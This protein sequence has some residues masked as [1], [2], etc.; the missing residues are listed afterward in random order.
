M[1]GSSSSSP[2]SSLLR[3][4]AV[5]GGGP[6]TGPF[7]CGTCGRTFSRNDSLAHHKTIHTGQTRCPVC[8]VLFTRK[9]TMKCHLFTAHGI[10]RNENNKRK[11]HPVYCD[12]CGKGFQIRD[13]LYKHR[14]VHRGATTCPICQAVLNRKGYLRRHLATV[15]GAD[16]VA[17]ATSAASAP[18][19]CPIC[20][21]GLR[22]SAAGPARKPSR[23]PPG[24][25]VCRTCGKRFRHRSSLSKHQHVHRGTTVCALCGAVLSSIDYLKRHVDAVHY[26]LTAGSSFGSAFGSPPT[27][28]EAPSAAAAANASGRYECALCGKTFY[29]R[30]SLR[31]H[32][33]VHKGAT[34][35]PICYTVLSRRAHLFRHLAAVHNVQADQAAAQ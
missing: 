21:V 17:S 27:L 19:T 22:A 26:F 2:S 1:S 15:H 3:D 34:R 8:G 4:V 31:Q 32:V 9:Y 11:V 29:A 20:R 35:C 6:G 12:I 14:S 23:P 33:S 7:R 30:R 16:S 13:S 5:A 10:K 24:H 28:H 18:T 25:H